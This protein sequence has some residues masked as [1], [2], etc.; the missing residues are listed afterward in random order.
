VIGW[1]AVT[2]QVG[3]PAPSSSPSSSTDAA[4]LLGALAADPEGLRGGRPCRCCRWSGEF[5]RPPARSASTR[6]CSWRF[7]LVLWSVA[8]MASSISPPRSSWGRSSCGRPTVC[9]ARAAHRRLDRGSHPPVSLLDH[10]PEPLFLAVAVDAL[11]AIP[12]S[13]VRATARARR[14]EETPPDRRRR[15]ARTLARLFRGYGRLVTGRSGGTR[16]SRIPWA[17]ATSTGPKSGV[18]PDLASPFSFD[19]ARKPAVSGPVGTA[20]APTRP[21]IPVG[22]VAGRIITTGGA[23]PDH[24]PCR[25][26]GRPSR[27]VAPLRNDD[28]APIPRRSPRRSPAPVPA[29][30][31]AIPRPHRLRHVQGQPPTSRFA[32]GSSRLRPGSWT[33]SC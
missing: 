14:R 32:T 6:S 13:E 11:V 1:A 30:H 24:R 9:G 21:G 17:S 22:K 3:L 28:R 23:P 31:E 2:G 8:R 10:V 15:S 26:G 4:P 27:R 18:R 19:H 20:E 25:T 33:R 29:D 5:R 12:S 7:S 16:D